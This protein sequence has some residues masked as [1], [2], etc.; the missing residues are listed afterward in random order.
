MQK[1]TKM[2]DEHTTPVEHAHRVCMERMNALAQGQAQVRMKEGPLFACLV[3]PAEMPDVLQPAP[4]AVCGAAAELKESKPGRYDLVPVPGRAGTYVAYLVDPAPGQV[5]YTHVSSDGGL[6]LVTG[7]DAFVHRNTQQDGIRSPQPYAEPLIT[8]GVAAVQRAL[9]HLCVSGRLVVSV[10]ML[11][12]GGTKIWDDAAPI[13][14]EPR[15][16]PD[17]PVVEIFVLDSPTCLEAARFRS[18]LEALW[19]KLLSGR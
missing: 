17:N 11:C 13:C 6:E 14:T 3:I 9:D 19:R 1:A 8:N 5:A 16:C 4:D 10:G 15:T 7:A 2:S 12:A 18:A